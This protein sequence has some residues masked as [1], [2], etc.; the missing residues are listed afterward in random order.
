[1]PSVPYGALAKEA[2]KGIEPLPI[3][4]YNVEVTAAEFKTANTGSP[5]YKIEFTVTDGPHKNR[6]VWR[7]AVLKLDNPNAVGFFFGQMRVLGLDAQFFAELP[8]DGAEDIVC[9]A[10][11]GKRA[12]A[13]IKHREWNGQIQNDVT[14]LSALTANSQPS[15]PSVSPATVI[16]T[17]TITPADVATVPAG[18]DGP[19]PT[20][21]PPTRPAG[22]PPGLPEGL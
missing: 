17:Q 14:K 1:M 6:K 13:E 8:D 16:D 22:T 4:P 3:G 2:A 12:I 20:A 19:V 18:L 10:L 9:Q 7:N 11:I 5:M 15:V 21:L